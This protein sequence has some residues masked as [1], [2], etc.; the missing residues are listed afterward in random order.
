MRTHARRGR[1]I[2]DEL[3]SNFGLNHFDY[4]SVLRNIAEFHHEAINGT[5]YPEGKKG[6]QIPL[7]ARIVAVADVFD[8]LT[9]NRPYKKAWSN[10][11]AFAMLKKLAGEKLDRDCVDAMVNNRK[12]VKEIQEQFKEDKFG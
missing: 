8:A 10:E 12:E 5:G 1:E 4:V 6:T 9:S 3:I 2:I 7:E 11:E